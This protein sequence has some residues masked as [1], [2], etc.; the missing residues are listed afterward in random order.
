MLIPVKADQPHSRRVEPASATA[1]LETGSPHP[2]S[3]SAADRERPLRRRNRLLHRTCLCQKPDIDLIG[4]GNGFRGDHPDPSGTDPHKP[5]SSGHPGWTDQP[6]GG[7]VHGQRLK[8]G[9]PRRRLPRGERQAFDGAHPDPTPVN[10]PGRS[11]RPE[12]I[13]PVPSSGPSTKSLSSAKQQ[14]PPA[15]PTPASR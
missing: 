9:D 3:E 1:G 14:E 10:E 13:D 12:K 8:R 5:D 2:S 4:P 11:C 15:W 7:S 6:P